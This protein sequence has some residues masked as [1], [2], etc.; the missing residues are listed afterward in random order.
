M[1]RRRF[2]GGHSNGGRKSK[3]EEQKLVERLTPLED[4]ALKALDQA[5]EDGKPWAVKM[6]FDYFYGK[7][8]AKY[9]VTLEKENKLKLDYSKLSDAALE[10][11]LDIYLNQDNPKD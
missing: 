2:N 6:F 5:L 9:D 10:E 8:I 7:P 11:I 3:A 4:K 1:D